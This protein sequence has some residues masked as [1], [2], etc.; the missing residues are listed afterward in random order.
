MVTQYLESKRNEAEA[1]YVET[2]KAGFLI[3]H[4]DD[5][6]ALWRKPWNTRVSFSLF[7]RYVLPYRLGQ[8]PLSDWRALYRER[9]Q[10][11]LRPVPE[12]ANPTYL[13]GVCTALNRDFTD[14]LYEPSFP[15]PEFPLDRL[16]DL[17]SGTCREFA[18]MAAAYGRAFGL[19]VAVDFAPQWGNRSLG[20][21]WCSAYVGGRWQPFQLGDAVPVG[22]H[23]S[24]IS[25]QVMPKVYRHMYSRQPGSLCRRRRRSPPA[26]LRPRHHQGLLHPRGRRSLPDG[27]L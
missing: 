22:E 25:Y 27:T 23:F 16:V 11:R 6:F 14:N 24:P 17:K 12:R 13:Y 5:A 2:V 3:R 10:D 1:V 21:D 8:E 7:C 18:L 4:I 26:Q 19:P 9:R 15:L 20:H